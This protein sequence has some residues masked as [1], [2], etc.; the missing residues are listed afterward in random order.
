M[1]AGLVS[2][3]ATIT[4]AGR[5]TG[6]AIVPSPD[7]VGADVILLA[8]TADQLDETENPS[9]MRCEQLGVTE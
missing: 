6:A 8:D 9:R 7:K 3:N 2:R 1:T 5:D 4:G